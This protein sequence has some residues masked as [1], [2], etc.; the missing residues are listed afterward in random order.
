MWLYVDYEP[1]A[2]F[3]LRPSNTT[4]NGGKSLIGPT[5]YAVKMALLDR[6]IRL[7][8][9]Q[10]GEDVFPLLRDM[11][12]HLRLPDKVAVN[13]TFQ[14]VLRKYESKI[15]EWT[16]TIAQREFIFYGGLLT[17][18]LPS[19]SDDAT[20]RLLLE[21]FAAVNYFG[22]RG[23]FVQM[24]NYGVYADAP[25]SSAGFVNASQPSSGSPLGFLQRMDDMLPD[26]AFAD[27]ST[28]NPKAD[29]A[30]RSYTVIFPYE[31]EHHGMNHTVY[32]RRTT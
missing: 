25:D 12:I 23:S 29:G 5:P 14:K 4:S 2:A 24:I 13:R 28:F 21:G 17:V 26:A 20:V 7:Y 3:G 32:R 8:G 19:P 31:L 27:V 1:V 9:V 10:L 6:L 11:P 22:R 18:A 30:R 15:R 16:S